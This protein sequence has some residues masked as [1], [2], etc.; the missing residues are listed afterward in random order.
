MSHDVMSRRLEF[1]LETLFAMSYEEKA[2]C[3]TRR[4]LHG[5]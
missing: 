4:R 3:H 2:A 5:I 1:S